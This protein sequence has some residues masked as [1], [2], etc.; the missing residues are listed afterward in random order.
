[1]MNF[2]NVIY[3]D[4]E[5]NEYLNELYE[6]LL[7]NYSVVFLKT[8]DEKRN[9]NLEDL[10]QFADILSKSNH[11]TKAEWHKVWGQEIASIA[12]YVYPNNSTVD[13]YL[14][15]ILS[16]NGNYRGLDLMNFDTFSDG[17]LGDVYNE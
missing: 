15:S 5:K 10:L 2:G 11:P 3:E 8:N 1:M 13:C 16:N 9:I 14:N 4:I 6:N 12:K 17:F 7:F